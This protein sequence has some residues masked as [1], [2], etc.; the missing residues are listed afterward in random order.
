MK[1]NKIKIL[2][3]SFRDGG[4]LNDWRFEPKTVR[5][6]YWALTKSGV[7]YVE[8]GFRGSEKYFDPDKFGIWKFSPE[9]AIREATANIKGARIAVLADY[10][11]VDLDEFCDAGESAV[12]LVRIATNRDGIEGAAGLAEK[13]KGKGY[14]VSLKEYR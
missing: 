9:E 8:I 13:I 12:D 5:E 6:T 4:Y 11:K 2:D 10:G 3:C 7:D 14:E 1:E